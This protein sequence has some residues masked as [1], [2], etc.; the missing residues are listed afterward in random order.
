MDKN[1]HSLETK[2]KRAKAVGL[3]SGGLDSTLAAKLMIEQRIEVHAI[4]F[5]SPFCMS[6]HKPALAIIDR[7]SGLRGFI[8]RPL[9]A[10]LIE[11]TIPEMGGLVDRGNLLGI[12]GR[13]LKKQMSLDVDKGIK[14]YSLS[15]WGLYV[16]GKEFRGE[17]ARLF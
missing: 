4:N 5:T 12:S 16:D 15:G 3:L 2:K 8:L 9:S 17:D 7:E 14:D 13:T 6:P 1:S 11:P 10:A